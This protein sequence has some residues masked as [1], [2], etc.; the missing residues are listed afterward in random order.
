MDKLKELYMKL[1]DGFR[2]LPVTVQVSLAVILVVSV[3][4]AFA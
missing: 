4:A 2:D 3:I 1:P